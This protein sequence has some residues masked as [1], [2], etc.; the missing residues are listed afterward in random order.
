MRD[1][2]PAPD[3]KALEDSYTIVGELRGSEGVRKYM[4]TRRDDGTEVIITL[5]SA[6]GG[7]ANNELSHFAADVQ[8]LSSLTHPG[9]A[10]VY[11]ARWLG[12]GSLAVVTARVQGKTLAEALR[13]GEQ[14][15]NPRT[16]VVLQEIWAVLDRAR[17]S[18]VV[19]RGVT[20]D[21]VYLSPASQDVVV[22]LG[23]M[24]IPVE[25]VNDPNGDAR[26]IGALAWSMLTGKAFVAEDAGQPLEELAPDLA[27]RV[28][29]ATEAM[30]HGAR[31]DQEEPDVPTFVGIV[32]AGDVL[33]QAEV[34]LA[35]MK[36]EYEEQHRIALSQCENH[37]LETERMATEQAELLA[38]ER[39]DFEQTMSEHEMELS[40][41]RDELQQQMSA[42]ER[43]ITE[44]ESR[45]GAIA[46][47]RTEQ[48]EQ[49]VQAR[50][51]REQA[52]A[53][54]DAE[55]ARGERDAMRREPSSVRSIVGAPRKV[56]L[57]KREPPPGAR[58]QWAIPAAALAIVLL[59]GAAVGG[60]FYF[61][62]NAMR[63][64]VPAQPVA[65]VSR[66]AAGSVVPGA[67]TPVPAPRTDSVAPP[68][69]VAPVDT[70]AATARQ[71]DA[72]VRR[73]AIDRPANAGRDM[74]P[75]PAP[76]TD[77][78]RADSVWARTDSVA[79]Q[80]SLRRDGALRDTS[81]PDT[82]FIRDTSRPPDTSRLHVVRVDTTWLDGGRRD[83]A[84]R[85]SAMK[86]DSAMRDT[87][88]I[89][90]DSIVRVPPP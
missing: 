73:R 63:K 55:I 53:D 29:D 74:A 16:A 12:K 85:D 49:I 10:R 19:H 23:P 2:Q 71:D 20:P 14:F 41:V 28:V 1:K 7:G 4:A 60:A 87:T 78:A 43:R 86:R 27:I 90:P 37:R 82:T 51:A 77:A 8:L 18:G 31:D 67:F 70:S 75:A 68:G 13:A 66:S 58:P 30:V 65:P 62:N 26:T 34:E 79:R 32:A 59:A 64:A 45:R 22:A 25:G 69:A 9:M 38:T 11:E 3:V 89:R 76:V 84:R 80:D 72:P 88:R 21:N 61:H 5:Y 57:P 52:A 81:R 35:A 36:E 48:E 6:P 54:K 44:F 40:A 50:R 46:R 56:V 33:K 15:S 39:A 47:V 24:P 42:L 83:S 17:A